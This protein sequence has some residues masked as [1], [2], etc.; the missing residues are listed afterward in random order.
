MGKEVNKSGL[1]KKFEEKKAESG[2]AK[3]SDKEVLEAVITEISA[4]EKTMVLANVK[5]DWKPS[6]KPWFDDVCAESFSKLTEAASTQDLDLHTK[7]GD[8][9]KFRVKN[10]ELCKAHFTLMDDKRK[11]F[12]AKQEAK[13]ERKKDALKQKKDKDDAAAIPEGFVKGAN[14]KKTFEYDDSEVAQN[15]EDIETTIKMVDNKLKNQEKKAKKKAAKEAAVKKEKEL[16][17]KKLKKI[18]KEKERR[19][20]KAAAEAAA[21]PKPAKVE[22]SVVEFTEE[23]DKESET[24]KKKIK[25]SKKH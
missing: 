14:K 12:N 2:D 5:R 9:K 25:K 13:E 8:F 19:K 17:P 7:A 4:A 16:D 18:Q 23:A 21:G 20:R 3:K 22:E 6:H 10:K 1:Q 24:P 15:D 11:S